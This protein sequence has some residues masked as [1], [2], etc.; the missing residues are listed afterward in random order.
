MIEFKNITKEYAGRK[1]LDSIS[2]CIKSGS[3]CGYIGPN[4][5]GKTTTARILTGLESPTSGEVI[6]LGEK[7]ITSRTDIRRMV[8]YVPETPRLYDALTP[9]ETILMVS[10]LRNYD[11]KK[12]L[13]K[14]GTLAE[15]FFFKDS[16]QAP[17]QTLSKGTR[18]KVVICLAL[19]FDPRILV[20][21]EPTDGLDVQAVFALKRL[22]K[23][24]TKRGG[25]V[26]YSSHLLDVV[27]SVCDQVLFINNGQ[28]AGE[29]AAESFVNNRGFLE[30]MFTKRI[31]TPND[32]VDSFF[33][34]D[35]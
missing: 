35:F 31:E 28:L 34:K 1:A 5:A 32:L 33:D 24:F 12:A 8:G 21:D 14:F 11:K 29:Y 17:I 18:Q 2:F 7:L 26:I 20:L 10:L 15:I 16:L 27:E 23:G 9:M 19:L 22:I 13:A 3:A 4:G 6:V 25:A 30:D